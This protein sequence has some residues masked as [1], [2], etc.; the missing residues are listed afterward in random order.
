MKKLLLVNLISLFYLSGCST[1]TGLIPSTW[2]D[3]QGRAIIDIRQSVIHIDCAENLP[4]QLNTI[5]QQ[6]E[7]FH[8]YSE[9]KGTNDMDNL[10]GK[11]QLTLTEFKDR[12]TKEKV[13]PFYCD[14]KKKLMTTQVDAIAKT[15][16]G[17]Y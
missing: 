14:L 12:T 9:S 4:A 10:I 7:W 11:F 16:L 5:N 1:I 15:V 17:R 2:D 6:T 13:S 8:L 3:N